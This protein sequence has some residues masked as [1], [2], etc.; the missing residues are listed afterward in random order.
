MEQLKQWLQ[1]GDRI[2]L[3]M[4]ANENVI[5]GPLCHKLTSLGF[6]AMAHRLAGF[7]PNTHVEG[8]ECIDEVW[9]SHGLEVTAIQLMSFHQSVGDHRTF[10]VDFTTIG[11][12]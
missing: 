10:L 9:A 1:Q 2:L 12:Q 3:Y 11:Q 4:D 6:T 8:K 7:V 5:D